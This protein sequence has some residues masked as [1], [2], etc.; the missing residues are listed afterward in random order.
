MSKLVSTAAEVSYI[1]E[2][3]CL[4]RC[5]AMQFGRKVVILRKNLLLSSDANSRFLLHTVPIAKATQHHIPK[6]SAL[7]T[8][9]LTYCISIITDNKKRMKSEENGS[10]LR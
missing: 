1:N 6:D 2:N 3:Y 8:L 7:R 9:N 4:L 10:G 5:D